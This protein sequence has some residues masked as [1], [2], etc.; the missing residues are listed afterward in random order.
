MEPPRPTFSNE[1]MNEVGER[2]ALRGEQPTN[3]AGFSLARK[4]MRKF[5]LVNLEVVINLKRSGH[6]F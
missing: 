5:G 6:V 2:C 3:M 1:T 4:K